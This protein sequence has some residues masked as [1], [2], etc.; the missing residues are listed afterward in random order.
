MEGDL[1]KT[2][3]KVWHFIWEDDSIWSWI[4]NIIL[5]FVIIK[6]LVYPGLGFALGTSHPVV[7]VVS[8]SMEHKITYDNKGNLVL[9][10]KVDEGKGRVN[11]DVYWDS[12]GSWYAKNTEITKDEF[13]EF[14]WGKRGFNTGDIMVLKS[15]APENIEI[16]DVIV[17]LV[18]SRSDPIIHRVV[19]KEYSEGQY[20]F[21]TKGD[22][23][24]AMNADEQRI[25]EGQIVGNSLFRIPWL[26]WIKIIFVGLIGLFGG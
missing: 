23:N 16:G 15:K 9:C 13:K 14:R 17:F 8:G 10:D 11:F 19:R 7:A 24:P 21:S 4:V 1:K 22:H 5:A 12:C 18:P 20:Y 25:S 6:F 26:G 2:W 3:K